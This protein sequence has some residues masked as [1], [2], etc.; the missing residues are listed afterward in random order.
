MDL[1]KTIRIL[2]SIVWWIVAWPVQPSMWFRLWFRS[3]LWFWLNKYE[4]T[5]DNQYLHHLINLVLELAPVTIN[6][7]ES[8]GSCQNHPE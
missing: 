2:T 8:K 5:E 6:S 4:Q 3:W 1:S 7:H